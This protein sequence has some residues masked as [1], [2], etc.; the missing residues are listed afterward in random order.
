[1]AVQVDTY[2]MSA[3]DCRYREAMFEH[4]VLPI[5][6]DLEGP[7]AALVLSALADSGC[8]LDDV[9]TDL[10]TEWALRH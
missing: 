9:V 7:D 1:M 4:H 8:R 5:R 10:L 6:T 3:S 2:D